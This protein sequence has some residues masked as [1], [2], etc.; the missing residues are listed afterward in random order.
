MAKPILKQPGV[1]AFHGQCMPAGMPQGVGVNV[2]DPGSIRCSLEQLPK[3]IACERPALRHEHPL[4]AGEVP[5][6]RTQTTQVVAIERLTGVL[7]VL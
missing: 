1:A 6:K 3:A 5:I 2:S 4:V 7:A